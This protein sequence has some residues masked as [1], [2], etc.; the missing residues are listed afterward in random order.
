MV[1]VIQE[2]NLQADKIFFGENEWSEHSF[3]SGTYSYANGVPTCI[4][5]NPNIT[6]NI[7]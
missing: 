2:T 1:F 7:V 4:L 6:T 3:Y 5:D